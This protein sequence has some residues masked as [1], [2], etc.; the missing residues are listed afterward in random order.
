MTDE[1]LQH[2]FFSQLLLLKENCQIHSL[3]LFKASDWTLTPTA[4]DIINS[5]HNMNERLLNF[6]KTFVSEEV[7]KI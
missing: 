4:V 1:I 3:E 5:C 6:Q 2:F 7:V